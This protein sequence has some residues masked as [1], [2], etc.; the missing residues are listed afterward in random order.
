[1]RRYTR[2]TLPSDGWGSYRKRTTTQAIRVD[3]PFTVE[4][5]EGT[6]SLPDGGWLAIDSRGWPYPIAADEFAAIYEPA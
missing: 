6:V 1:M 4:T 3:E 5:A 2:D